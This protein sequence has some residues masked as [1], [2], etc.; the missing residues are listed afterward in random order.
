MA[1]VLV[2][3]IPGASGFASGL[4]VA[5]ELPRGTVIE[6]VGASQGLGF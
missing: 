3:W 1:R 5:A 4:R 6:M 2:Y